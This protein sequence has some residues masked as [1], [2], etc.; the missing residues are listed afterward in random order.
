MKFQLYKRGFRPET[1]LHPCTF[2]WLPG[3]G[4]ARGAGGKP[5]ST[6]WW[7]SVTPRVTRARRGRSGAAAPPLP[8]QGPLPAAGAAGSPGPETCI[9][10]VSS[11]QSGC[12]INAGPRLPPALLPLPFSPPSRPLLLR[13]C[14]GFNKKQDLGFLS[15]KSRRCYDWRNDGQMGNFQRYFQTI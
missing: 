15:F 8:A 10:T 7:C 11:C 9:G 2:P 13:S 1:S 14:A 12:V 6:G 4:T 5:A 3:Q